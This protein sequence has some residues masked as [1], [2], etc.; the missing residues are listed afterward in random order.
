MKDHYAALGLGTEAHPDLVAAAY[1]LLRDRYGEGG[2]QEDEARLRAVEEA[3]KVL[4]DPVRRRAYDMRWLEHRRRQADAELGLAPRRSRA[5]QLLGVLI[6]L[7]A[8]AGAASLWM[9]PQAPAPIEKAAVAAPAPQPRPAAQVAAPS[10]LSVCSDEAGCGQGPALA[11]SPGVTE[12]SIPQASAA[13]PRPR[14]MMR[15]SVDAT[16]KPR[17][18]A[19]IAVSGARS[20]DAPAQAPVRPTAASPSSLPVADLEETPLARWE[21]DCASGRQASCRLLQ[22][23][24]LVAARARSDASTQ[25]EDA[26]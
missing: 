17:P 18:R 19:R 12:A 13:A 2:V 20:L 3:H 15:A 10:S 14:P 24:R 21:R 1:A 16:P 26:S 8:G 4:A 9:R 25:S 22:R 5:L 6:A 11:P 7:A 23:A